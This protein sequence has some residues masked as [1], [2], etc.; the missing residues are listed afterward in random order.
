MQQEEITARFDK[1]ASSYDQQ[2]SKM[3]AI[4]EA[5]YLLT[6]TILADL[7][8]QAKILCV[9]AGTGAEILYLAQKFPEWH[10]TAVEPSAAMLEV[11]RR[12]AEEQEIAARCVFH[13]GYLDSLPATEPFDA[14]TAFLVSQFILDRHAR[15]KFFQAIA[16]RL[17]PAGLLVSADLAGDLAAPECQE[18]LS[19]WSRVMTG[20]GTPP[21]PE[22]IERMR[23]T[24]SQDVGV[25][26]PGDVGNILIRGGFDTP[27]RFFQ[28]GMIHA[29]IA[30]QSLSQENQLLSEGDIQAQH[31]D[32]DG[33]AVITIPEH[34]NITQSGSFPSAYR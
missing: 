26:P 25:L 24:Y 31:I 3:A 29:W 27:M 23:Q 6:R 30:R 17:R 11:F 33:G 4:Y 16:D 15:S 22:A 9:G 13:V 5:L 10:F 18:M 21:S 1:Q 19:L 28:A 2:W 7:P 8:A 12:R 14:A 34:K 32:T 20:S